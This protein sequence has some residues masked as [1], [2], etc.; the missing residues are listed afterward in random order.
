MIVFLPP[1]ATIFKVD[2]G[3]LLLPVCPAMGRADP[4]NPETK[5]DA[6]H[7]AAM[8]VEGEK[9]LTPSQQCQRFS[10]IPKIYKEDLNELA[11]R[12]RVLCGSSIPVTVLSKAHEYSIRCSAPDSAGDFLNILRGADVI[13]CPG[14]VSDMANHAILETLT[15]IL[16]TSQRARLRARGARI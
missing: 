9:E 2:E 5:V 16:S 11:A 6:A 4:A 1:L 7:R 3:R 10:Y 8:T 15:T 12:S 13:I 14:R